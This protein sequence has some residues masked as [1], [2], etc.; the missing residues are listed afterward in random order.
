MS[1]TK[2]LVKC[3]LG[4]LL[5]IIVIVGGIFGIDVKVNVEDTEIEESV[6]TVTT[7]EPVAAENDSTTDDVVESDQ[8]PAE[9]TP[10]EDQEESADESVN[11]DVTDITDKPQN[12]VTEEGEN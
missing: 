7:F 5:S 12:I 4:F 8:S 9:S 6:A 2:G 11:E 10:A 3:V 1:E